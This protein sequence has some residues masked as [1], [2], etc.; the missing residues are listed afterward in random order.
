M[1]IC[2]CV[3]CDLLFPVLGLGKFCT[4]VAIITRQKMQTILLWDGD[5]FRVRIV[6]YLFRTSVTKPLYI[7][8]F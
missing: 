2:S 1:A 6:H 8:N 4:D 5:G 7:N 3:R